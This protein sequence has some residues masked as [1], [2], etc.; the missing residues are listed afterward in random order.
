M[1][2]FL[3]GPSV[4]IDV[5]GNADD[6]RS[7]VYTHVIRD[8]NYERKFLFCSPDLND[9][10]E[11][12]M[13]GHAA[14]L[15]NELHLHGIISLDAIVDRE[16]TKIIDM[17]LMLPLGTPLIDLH[18][19]GL[20][21]LEMLI[22]LYTT[23]DLD[24][25]SLTGGRAVSLEHIIVEGG[26]LRSV[27]EK[28]MGSLSDPRIVEGLFGSDEM[29]TDFEE[30]KDRWAATV[31]FCGDTFEE[32]RSKRMHCMAHI[33]HEEGLDASLDPALEVNDL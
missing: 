23:G 29:I 18:S 3:T 7:L 22:Q 13:R 6:S 28:R 16:V 12:S 10:N 2:E 21:D 31:I 9:T 30:G 25:P 1:Q 4:T 17:E 26:K 15:A 27:P 8:E 5:I 24:I 33:V 32:A 11:S 20:N 19:Q 14:M